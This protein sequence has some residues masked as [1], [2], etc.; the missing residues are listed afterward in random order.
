MS[1]A[2]TVQSEKSNPFH[3][4]VQHYNLVLVYRKH[5]YNTKKSMLQTRASGS[6]TY[7]ENRFESVANTRSGKNLMAFE[8]KSLKKGKKNTHT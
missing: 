7:S 8:D 2:L 4:S 5:S 3:C 1:L 6:V